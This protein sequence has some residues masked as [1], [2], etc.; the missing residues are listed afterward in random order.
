MSLPRIS[1]VTPSLNQGQFL[2]TCI[3]SVL[4]QNYP[5][6]EYILIDGG[7]SDHSMEIVHQ[8]STHFAF[9]ISE[10][11]KGQSDAINKGLRRASGKLVSWLNA[12]DF[13]L[14]GALAAVAQ[15]YQEDP[16]AS[17]YYGDGL[18]V[19][20][21][22]S[23][24]ENFFPGGVRIF[25][26][27]AMIY[28][29]NFILQPTAF[30]NRACLEIAGYLDESLHWGLDN[31]LWIRLSRQAS[32]IAIDAVLAAS[33]EWGSTKTST[34]SFQRIEELR[35]LA[36]RHGGQP[37]TPGVL[38]YQLDTLRRY[39]SENPNIYPPEYLAEIDRFWSAT[40]NLLPRNYRTL[41]SGYPMT[42]EEIRAWEQAQTSLM[43]PDIGSRL[44]RMI[45]KVLK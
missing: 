5:D 30:I 17:F 23:R 6:L 25:N 14:P 39:A 18:R 16:S 27:E 12:D 2:E 19:R 28:G 32:P 21:D 3:R 37:I 41:P 24:K 13:L 35:Q 33:R 9:Q 38:C 42:D 7:S 4:D 36:E 40:A 44:K 31:D 43:R 1:I 15:A 11:D 29:L 45:K 20:E 8:Y 26:Q 22:G 10:K 34:G